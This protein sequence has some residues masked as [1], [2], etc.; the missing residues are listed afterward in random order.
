M[1]KDENEQPSLEV[2]AFIKRLIGGLGEFASKLEEAREKCR[3]R[4][5]SAGPE[6]RNRLRILLDGLMAMLANGITTP[7]AVVNEK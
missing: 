5:R 7:I 2:H 4:Y 3:A 1:A 6:P